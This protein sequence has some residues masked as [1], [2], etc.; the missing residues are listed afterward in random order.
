[1]KLCIS[2]IFNFYL[3]YTPYDVFVIVI[4]KIFYRHFGNN[5]FFRNLRTLALYDL[6][7]VKDK[8]GCENIIQKAV[9]NC[10]IKIK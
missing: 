8:Q 4:S 2:N 10:Q 5:Y 7:E 6:P 9:P 1:M 3:N